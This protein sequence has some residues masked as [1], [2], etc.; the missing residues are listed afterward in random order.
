MK[1]GIGKLGLDDFIKGLVVVVITAVLTYLSQIINVP[2]FNLFEADWQQVI[3][4][5]V[6]SGIGY[7]I[8]NLLTTNDGN[9][10]GVAG[11]KSK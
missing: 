4:I 3:R 8:K 10:L 7:I 1:N 2:G 5:A 9:V 11:A 6:T